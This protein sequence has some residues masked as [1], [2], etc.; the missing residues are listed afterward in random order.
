[1][2]SIILMTGA[3]VLAMASTVGAAQSGSSTRDGV[4]TAAQANQGQALYTKQCA[5]CHGPGLEGSGQ[6]PPLAGDAFMQNWAGQT[7][8]DLFGKIQ[9]TMPA[10]APG[11][12]KPDAVTQAIAYILKENKFPA[13]KKPLP[14]SA[15]KLQNIHIETP[16]ASGQ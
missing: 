7:L 2:R 10:T 14:D 5:M 3:A 6:N 9:A 11:S 8:A 15:E 13:G 1:M 16:R 12:L 4:Y